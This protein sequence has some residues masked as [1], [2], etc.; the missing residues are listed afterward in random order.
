MSFPFRPFLFPIPLGE[1]GRGASG[2]WVKLQQKR[3][4]KAVKKHFD[5]IPLGR[6][7]GLFVEQ[8]KCWLA[9]EGVFKTV[10]C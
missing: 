4:T 6:L 2:C 9:V 3:K 7:R 5:Q 1:K 10:T 8:V